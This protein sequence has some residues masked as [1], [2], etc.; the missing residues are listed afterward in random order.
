MKNKKCSAWWCFPLI[1]FLTSGP[2]LA[3]VPGSADH[4]QIGRFTGAEIVDYHQ[5]AF[6]DYTLPT[7]KVTGR[8]IKDA[9]TVE[10]KLTRITYI[11]PADVSSLE[12][13]R[14][15]EEALL[16][17]GF[18]ILFSCKDADCGGR[19][20]NH[21]M[22]NPYDMRLAEN[23][24]DQRYLALR[25]ARPDEGDVYTNIYSVRNTSGGGADRDRIYTRIHVVELKPRERQVE[26]IP[27]DEMARQL[28]LDGRVALYGI[29][30]D[31][32]SDQLKPESNPTLEEIAKLL[33]GNPQLA[34]LVV[35]H[36]DN[37]GRLDY[38]LDLSKRRAAS[39]VRALTGQHGIDG[40]RLEPHGVAF[41]APVATNSS[42]DGRAKNRRVE[43][44][45]R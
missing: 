40:S 10:G 3:D 28:D 4:P 19:S 13:T 35:G 39:V 11:N 14:A 43:L 1:L 18:E 12:V 15:Y 26:I 5:D 32:D 25:L 24:A 27:A 37:Q 31:L 2:L 41:L 9:V 34:L 42:E 45:P 17:Q 20:F 29:Y 36:T 44:V 23:Y 16:S 22:N 7:A 30:F 21:A 6:S 33:Q 38:N 8:E